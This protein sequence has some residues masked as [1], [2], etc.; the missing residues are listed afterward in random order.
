MNGSFT[1]LGSFED[2]RIAS[3]HDPDPEGLEISCAS[4]RSAVASSKAKTQAFASC[5]NPVRQPPI[6]RDEQHA[7]ERAGGGTSNQKRRMD[8]RSIRVIHWASSGA[9]NRHLASALSAYATV[10]HVPTANARFDV[11]AIIRASTGCHVVVLELSSEEEAP[12]FCGHLRDAGIMLPIV[13]IVQNATADT[14]LA[15]LDAGATDCIIRTERTWETV[16]RIRAQAQAYRRVRPSE[17]P[18][19]RAKYDCYHRLL[20][21]GGF[22]VQLSPNEFRIIRVLLRDAPDPVSR[23]VLAKEIWGNEPSRGEKR[24]NTGMHK[25]RKKLRAVSADAIRI[26][27]EDGGYKFASFRAAR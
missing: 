25:L 15:C 6:F 21:I 13:A 9:L 1:L 23:A 24:L 18:A 8:L 3:R 7:A 17:A 19:A 4:V 2:R 26:E 10:E 16:A 5:T 11:H 27:T 14:V 22:K 20:F 12:Q